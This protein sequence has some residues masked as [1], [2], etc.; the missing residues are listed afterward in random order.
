MEPCKNE[1]EEEKVTK[2][3]Y[4]PIE[5]DFTEDA[6]REVYKNELQEKEINFSESFDLPKETSSID[7]E[8]YYPSRSVNN[9]T[10]ET[11]KSEDIFYSKDKLYEGANLEIQVGAF[12]DRR[13]AKSL[14]EKLSEFEAYIKRDFENEKYLYKV[15]IGPI[16]NINIANNIKKKLSELGYSTISLIMK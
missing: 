13:N 10:E 9:T 11:I 5:I 15:R 2:N 12:N 8:I 7:K 6:D 16:E 1:H 14:I 4:K 3:N